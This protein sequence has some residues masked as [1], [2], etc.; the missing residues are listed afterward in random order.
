M[1]VLTA[2]DDPVYRVLMEEL[3]SEWGFQVTCVSDGNEAW[4][5]IGRDPT[6]R[7]AALDWMMPGMDG[8]TLCRRLKERADREIYVMLVTG[9]GKKDQIERVLVAGADDYLMKPFEPVDLKIRL[10]NAVRVI[11][12]QDELA[13]R[14]QP[15][16]KEAPRSA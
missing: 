5:A 14:A 7:L 4:E 10:R 11:E 6:I 15:R 12:L 16:H 2:D 8:Y 1:H 9:S 13:G 3:L